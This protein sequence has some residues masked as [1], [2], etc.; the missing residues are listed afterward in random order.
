MSKNSK[1]FA[2]IPAR[3]GSVGLPKKNQ[4]LF[5]ST[6]NFLK[7]LNWIN[8]TIVTSDDKV[9]LDKAILNN[10]K[11]YKRSNYLS[12]S[13]IS[14]KSVFKDLIDTLNFTEDCI[15]WLFYLPIVY[16]NLTDFQ[17]AKK[18][19]EK[20]SI[21]SLCS[22][23]PSKTHPFNTWVYDKKNQKINQFIKNDIFRRQDLPP[24]W[25]HYHYICCFKASEI[26]KLNNELINSETYPIFLSEEYSKNLVEIDT[27][28]DLERWS[29]VNNKL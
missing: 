22:F 26:D 17:N 25:M 4:I 21:K 12:G 24:A 10:F 14:I 6:A 28:E 3:A 1:H 2:I 9:I 5:D 19:I 16:K 23:V 13:S 27:L 29:Q 11:E 15:L 8:E 7:N 20:N 18:I